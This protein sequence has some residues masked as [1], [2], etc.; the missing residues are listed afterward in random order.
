VFFN[1]LFTT[2]SNIKKIIYF[3]ENYFLEKPLSNKK[4]L[5]PAKLEKTTPG[6][7]EI[8]IYSS[9]K[10]SFSDRMITSQQGCFSAIMHA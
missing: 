1:L 9:R 10:I 3:F 7:L 8:S 6:T 4:K 5:F 2:L